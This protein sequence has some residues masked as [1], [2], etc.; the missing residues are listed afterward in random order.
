MSLQRITFI[1]NPVAG[2]RDKSGFEK[3]LQEIFRPAGFEMRY[4]YT[5]YPSHAYQYARREVDAG[6]KIVVAVGGD[7]TIN[8]VARALIHTATALGV[9]PYGS[10]NGF[11]RHF[12][13]PVKIHKA[14][15]ILKKGHIREVDVGYLNSK[16]FFCTSGVGFDAETGYYFSHY[17]KRGFLSYALSFLRVYR[18]YRSKHYDIEVNGQ[19]RTYDA[20]F[21][22]IAN[23]SQFGF[24]FYIAPGASAED[25]YF[26]LVVVKKFP[27]WKGIFLAAR[28]FTGTIHKSKYVVVEKAREIKL[29]KPLEKKVIHIDGDPGFSEGILHYRLESGALRVIL[30]ERP[31]K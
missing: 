19:R 25:G 28:S 17:H 3:R 27:K 12:G 15:E 13:L 2:G 26:D 31:D 30:P 14:L 22:N 6:T 7:G 11:A 4:F 20:F 23:I 24:H 10:G 29:L 8:E 18:N 9:I 16:P 21:I 5:R 1:I